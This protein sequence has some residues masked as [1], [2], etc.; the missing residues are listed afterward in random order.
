[1]ECP[2][3]QSLFSLVIHGLLKWSSIPIIL[4]LVHL[5]SQM[6]NF[7]KFMRSVINDCVF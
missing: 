1:M 7:E 3:S 6:N 4:Y 5:A 2:I